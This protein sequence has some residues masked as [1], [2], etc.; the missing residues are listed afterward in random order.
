M[1]LVLKIFSH[2]KWTSG[3]CAKDALR[4]IRVQSKQRIH[5]WIFQFE[6][7][8]SIKTKC[9][10]LINLLI[11]FYAF[12]FCRP[13]ICFVSPKYPFPSRVRNLKWG[14]DKSLGVFSR[15]WQSDHKKFGVSLGFPKRIHMW[16]GREKN[17]KCH[18]PMIDIN[19]RLPL[20]RILISLHRVIPKSILVFAVGL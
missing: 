9:Q 2:Y 17:G 14:L 19:A 20:H 18:C 15:R 6:R 5:N 10:T 13:P 1:F 8:H 4:H 16:K 12:G 7:R 3:M 11:A